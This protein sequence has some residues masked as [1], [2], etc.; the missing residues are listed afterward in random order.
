MD[1]DA[2]LSIKYK[3]NTGEQQKH[4]PIWSSRLLSRNACIV[5]YS[6]ICQHNPSCKQTER[7]KHQMTISTEA[8]NALTKSNTPSCLKS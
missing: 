2:K 8:A 3:T 5:Q 1:N 4:H 6:E 7:Y